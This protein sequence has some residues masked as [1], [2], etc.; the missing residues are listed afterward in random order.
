MNPKPYNTKNLEIFKFTGCKDGFNEHCD[1][2]HIEIIK[3]L[4]ETFKDP[5]MNKDKTYF[6]FR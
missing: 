5:E 6:G 2:G 4:C 1:K 3:Y